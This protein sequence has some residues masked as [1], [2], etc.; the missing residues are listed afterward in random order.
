MKSPFLAALFLTVPGCEAGI[1]DYLIAASAPDQCTPPDDFPV[2]LRYRDPANACAALEPEFLG[3]MPNVANPDLPPGSDSDSDVRT[4]VC[5]TRRD[6]AVT[7]TFSHFSAPG[8]VDRSQRG[9]LESDHQGA[10]LWLRNA[11]AR[12]LLSGRNGRGA[13]QDFTTDQIRCYPELFE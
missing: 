6:G 1:P 4:P 3:C 2:T 13:S 10:W 12:G 5:A 8:D 11:I 7:C 9:F